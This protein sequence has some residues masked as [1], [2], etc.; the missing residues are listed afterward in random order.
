[1]DDLYAKAILKFAG[2]ECEPPGFGKV[3]DFQVATAEDFSRDYPRKP[4]DDVRRGWMHLKEIFEVAG[5]FS[6]R[7]W[8]N[9]GYLDGVRL[10]NHR[11]PQPQTSGIQW[12]GIFATY[13]WIHGQ[14]P[15][16]RWAFPGVAGPN[17]KKVW[18]FNGLGLGDIAVIAADNLNHHFIFAGFRDENRGPSAIINTINGN[19]DGQSIKRGPTSRGEVTLGQV[20]AYYTVVVPLSDK[21]K[22]MYG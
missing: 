12:C 20:V 4:G 13:C 22:S 2:D 8:K 14:V 11:V 6:E 5:G 18:G 16:V 17:V 9:E 7:T 3:N 10:K 1:M 15:G 21:L 19:S